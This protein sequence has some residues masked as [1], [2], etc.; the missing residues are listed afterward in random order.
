MGFTK[1]DLYPRIDL[2]VLAARGNLAGT[3]KTDSVN[4]TFY[5]APVLNWEIDFW[6]KYRRANE[7]SIATLLASQYS[8]RTV[9]IG[10]IR[11]G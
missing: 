3:A 7:A 6:G 9:Q 4:N 10:L 5:I 11:I 1:A 2:E 8:L